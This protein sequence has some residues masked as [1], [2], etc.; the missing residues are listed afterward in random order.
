MNYTKTGFSYI[1]WG[2]Y[3]LLICTLLTLGVLGITAD[4]QMTDMTYRILC[5]GIFFLVLFGVSFLL[6]SLFG[7]FLSKKRTKSADGT[8]VEM[9]AAT[10][11]FLFIGAFAVKRL[12]ISITA[13]DGI[14]QGDR[15]YFELAML[16]KDNAVIP[17]HE[18]IASYVFTWMLRGMCMM[19]GNIEMSVVLL[20]TVLLLTAVIFLYFAVRN[21]FG[22]TAALIT[23]LGIAVL[24]V[25]MNGLYYA[26]AELFVLCAVCIVF[27][28]LSLLMKFVSRQKFHNAAW[29][30]V[31]FLY[32][33]LTAGLIYLDIIGVIVLLASLA[34][35]FSIAYKKEATDTIAATETAT[36][37]KRP[38]IQNH[39]VQVLFIVLGSAAGLLAMFGTRAYLDHMDLIEVLFTYLSVFVGNWQGLEGI[40]YFITDMKTAEYAVLYVLAALFVTGFFFVNQDKARSI[41]LFTVGAFV[42][43][44]GIDGYISY[45]SIWKLSLIL[46]A[47]LGIQTM[48]DYR[49]QKYAEAEAELEE[50]METAEEYLPKSETSTD[51]ELKQES[52]SGIAAETI[53]AS[54]EP[55]PAPHFIENPLP[56]PKKHV[57][58]TM[59]YAIDVADSDYDITVNE[60]D[61]FDI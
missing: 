54:D 7:Q 15:T 46:L 5:A 52:E 30:I 13:A 58:K 18:H 40:L 33:V 22:K 44:F 16:T 9:I 50:H 35:F 32:G 36:T 6:Y 34:A 45:D 37:A 39:F 56:L 49:S 31:F 59:D 23:L 3:T 4:Y 55:A 8:A 1:A 20:Q 57:P 51:K 11:V 25:F 26:T 47:A 12:L 10:T 19:F 48:A 14:L 42:L 61:D 38:F 24:P 2:I 28:I 27:F 29:G 41:V 17:W 60:N 43:Q 21:M 53:M